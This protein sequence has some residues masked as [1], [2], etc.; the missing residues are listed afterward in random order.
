METSIICK[1]YSFQIN[2]IRKMDS[3][4]LFIKKFRAFINYQGIIAYYSITI[5][6]FELQLKYNIFTFV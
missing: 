1:K 4:H 5:Q 3:F 6:T 2:F